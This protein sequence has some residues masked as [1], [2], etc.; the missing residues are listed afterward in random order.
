VRKLAFL[1]VPLAAA[2]EAADYRGA[3][4][5]DV[6]ESL[7][8]GGV[9]ILY[10]SDLVKPWMRVEQEPRA[11]E[12]RALLA[13]ILSRHGIAVADGPGN[14]LMLVREPPR[15]PRHAAPG[16]PHSPAPAPIE[17]VV[18]SASHYQFGDETSLPV[19]LGSAELESLPDIGE[20]P[21]RAI[22]RLPGVAG[23]DF[24]SRYHLRGGTE[25]ETLIRY[26][27]LRLYN[28]YHLKDFFGIFSS[29]DPAIVSD[30]R[31]YT[32]GF[33]AA[34][35]DRSSGVVDIAPRLT[36]RG[37]QGE[38]VASLFSA[39]ASF[40]GATGDGA[41]DWA[42]AA[43]RGNMDV[44]FDLVDSTLGEPEYH[45]VYGRVG[46]RF[47]D[48]L[49]VSAS[50]LAFDDEIIAFDSDQEEEAVAEYRDEYYWIRADLGAPDG[51]GGRV[52]AAHTRLDSERTG[53]A[54][55]PGVGSGT[56]ADQ[57]EFTIDSIQADGWWR[58]GARSL[59]QAGFE[60]RDQQGRYDYADEA[61]FELLFLTPGAPLTPSRARDI[62]L[63]PSGQQ[64]GAYVNWRFGPVGSIVTDVGMRWDRETLSDQDGSQWSPRAVLMWQPIEDTRLRLGWGRYYQ[65]QS[66]NELQVS[67]G[68]VSYQPAQ[69]ATH[70]VAS[71]EHDLTGAMTLRAELYRKDYDDP[72]ARYENLL[73]TLVVLPEL[74]P[75]RILIAPEK[76]LAEGAEVS[77]RYE[78]DA[79]SGWV[80]YTHSRVLDRVAGEWLHRSWDQRDYASG[81]LSWRGDRWEASL[82]AA[83]HRGWPTTAVEL[84]TLEPFP[85][86]TAGK[87]NA[88][89]LSNYARVDLRVARRFDIGAA[90]ELTA[91]L[92]V[93]NVTKRSNDCCAEYE[94]EDEDDSGESVPVFL[95]IERLPSLPLIPSLGVLWKF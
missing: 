52:L 91:F 11:T 57:R 18:V 94:L 3:Q 36:G 27:D 1:L 20:D 62:H 58:A 50:A 4:V 32:G 70:L 64:A 61:E 17:A 68:Q 14:S 53:S 79:F 29:I 95:E 88:D 39:G 9:E 7:R 42:F 76:S 8:S 21:V 90:G 41:T 49:A 59:L 5:E 80:A 28:P 63:R 73:N 83:W 67:D 55:L 35:G 85:L 24:T 66:V 51:L 13:E 45:D 60:W 48:W 19:V 71:I 15:T 43:R 12:P 16:S 46:R 10:S 81:G 65:A 22:A 26:D 86:A 6:L 23:Q 30:I 34:F 69:R 56:L 72:I 75:D 93:S 82:A 78:R 92:E 87:R 37:F 33:P 47:N 89:N 77:L 25:E 74:K 40:D 38:A 31:V 44:F 84:E 2:A 54:D